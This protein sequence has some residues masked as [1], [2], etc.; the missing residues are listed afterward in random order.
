MFTGLIEA[1]AAITRIERD[2]ERKVFVIESDIFADQKIGDSVAINGVCLTITGLQ[3]VCASFD[4][5]AETLSR[6]NLNSL[7]RLDTVNLERALKADGR[8]G[9]HFVTGH[10]DRTVI[11]A[12]RRGAGGSIC[13]TVTVPADDI[14][15]VVEKGSIAVNGVSLTIAGVSSTSFDVH[16][17]PQTLHSTT[18]SGI[19]KGEL[20]NVEYDI[21]GKY[22]LNARRA[23]VPRRELDA[24]FLKKKGFC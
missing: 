5:I 8:L 18:L 2:G 13:L 1:V 7:K 19:K 17:I 21:I 20:V 23:G 22:I 10:I 4:A 14:A 24:D 6:S 15:L 3:G 16:L 9:G 11:V 12:D